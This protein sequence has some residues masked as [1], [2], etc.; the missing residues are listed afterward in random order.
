MMEGLKEALEYIN[1]LKE[2]SLKPQVLEIEGKTYCTRNMSRYHN[3]DMASELG[4]NTLTAV[5]DYIKGK[6]E[7]LRESMILHVNSPT[8][9]KLYSGL[10]YERSREYLLE[11]NAIVNEFQFDHY[12]DQERFLIELQANFLDTE[13]LQKIK[14]V[15]GNIQAGTTTNYDDDGVSQRT[16]INSG[17]ANKTDV[18]VPNPV[19]LRPYRT[20]AEIEQP[21][22]GY[23]FRIKD[24]ERGPAFKLVEA[25][26]G[27]WKNATM[28]K[29][30]EYLEFELK[31]K[32]DKYHIT[33]I[34]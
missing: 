18:I 29:I 22:S 1:D 26:G 15:S 8:K 31:E 5:V 25:D 3:F 11:A 16:T 30:K 34:A 28:K 19:M 24:S 4:V 21:E 6:P 20:F 12:Y 7:E 14:M 27:L 2:E 32:L 10:I 23:I 17:I 33:V 9:V 13:D